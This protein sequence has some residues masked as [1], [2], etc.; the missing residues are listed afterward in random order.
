M[1]ISK[2]QVPIIEE[3]V[4]EGPKVFDDLLWAWNGFLQLSASRPVGMG[5]P[6]HIPFSEIS[7]YCQLY[8]IDSNNKRI[9]FA[10]VTKVLDNIWIED[11]Y[12]KTNKVKQAEDRKNKTKKST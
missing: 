8:G 3:I 7:H 1:R 4:D 6:M 9:F 11:Y 10:N 12:D 5:G 2:G